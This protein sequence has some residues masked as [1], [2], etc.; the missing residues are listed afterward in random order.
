[1]QRM[2]ERLHL[3]RTVALLAILCTLGV[4]LTGCGSSGSTRLTQP[5]YSAKLAQIMANPI[6]ARDTLYEIAQSGTADATEQMAPAFTQLQSDLRVA[7]SALTKLNPP[8]NAVAAHVQLQHGMT[9]LADELDPII[10]QA[11]AGD[12]H[13]AVD[14]F[15]QARGAADQRAASEKLSA[16]GYS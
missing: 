7:A 11:E 16:L 12:V 1:M 6:Q 15:N 8:A 14:A 3:R 9:E 10:A 2:T 4:G 13:G 5:Q